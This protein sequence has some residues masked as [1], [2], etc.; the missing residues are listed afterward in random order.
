MVRIENLIRRADFCIQMG[1][2]GPVEFEYAQILVPGPG[3]EPFGRVLE[4][5]PRVY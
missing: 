5:I 4:P 2:M 3:L 1:S